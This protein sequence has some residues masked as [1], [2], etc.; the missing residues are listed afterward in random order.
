MLAVYKTK[1]ERHDIL[2]GQLEQDYLTFEPF[3]RELAE[4]ILP[5]RAQF[6]SSDANKGDRRNQ[7]VIDTTPV[8]SV[9]RLQSGLMAGMVS[10]KN[11]WFRMTTSDPWLSEIPAVKI[12]LKDVEDGINYI[13]QRSNFYKTVPS[14]L[15][16]LPV[17]ATSPMLVE[18]DFETLVRF[19]SIP[20][21]SYRI[22]QDGKGNVN[23][24]FRKFRMTVRQLISTFGE[25]KEKPGEINWEVF[26]ETV[27][28]LYINGNTESWVEVCHVIEPNPDYDEKRLNAKFKKFSSCYYEKGIQAGATKGYL[29]SGYAKYLRESGYDYFPVLCPRWSVTGEDV[30]GTDCP[31]MQAIGDVKQLHHGEKRAAEAI[32]KKVRPPM[33]GTAAMRG[34]QM[35]FLPA[36]MTWIPEREA[37]NQHALQQAYEVNFDIRE[38]NE[39][40]EMLRNRIKR[41]FL[42][43]VILMFSTDRGDKTA[44]EVEEWSQEKYMVLGPTLE[45]FNNDFGRPLLEIIWQLGNRQ[46]FFP[47][48]PE[49][50]R[51][52]DLKIEFIS[53]MNT[54]QKLPG[55]QG[56]ERLNGFILS[57][58]EVQP[59]ILDKVDFDQQVDEYGSAAGVPPRVIRSDDDVAAMRQQRAQAAKA[60]QASEMI[61]TGAGAAKDLSETDVTGDNALTALLQGARGA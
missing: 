54:A 12:Y 49:Q 34:Q 47:E 8:T 2:E 55:L 14:M 16:D 20:V 60:Q 26:S 3:Y 35:N 31:G 7:K 40:Q 19:K 18:E 41:A 37:G 15:I 4:N 22:A 5:R 25:D 46:R 57:M 61:A 39:R 43:D 58:A 29:G 48:P 27:K 1:R 30:Y 36:G 59:D 45:L 6:L 17:F 42:E 33:K 23:T 52:K 51:G 9:V 10:Q 38:H 50:L 21:G 53:V 56:M 11:P 32:D 44:R 13:L 28:Q 24:F